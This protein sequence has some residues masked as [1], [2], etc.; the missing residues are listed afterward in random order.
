VLAANALLLVGHS[1]ETAAGQPGLLGAWGGLVQATL[2]HGGAI[3]ILARL[4]VVLLLFMVGLES[5]LAAMMQ[6]GLSSLLVA[7]VGVVAPFLLGF[8]TSYWLLPGS[9]DLMVHVFIGAT[10]AATSVGITARVLRELGRLDQPESRI[11]LGAA[12]IDDVMGLVLLAVVAGSITAQNA[13]GTLNP[14][15]VVRIAGVAL[16]FL[17]LAVVVGQRLAPRVFGLAARLPGEG[18][19]LATALVVCFL[20]AGTA[21]LI[22]LAP[23]VGAFAAGLLLDRVHYRDFRLRGDE[24]DVEE[25]IEPLAAFLVPVFFVQMGMT[26]RLE[27]FA[28]PAVIGF[29]ALLTLAAVLGKQVC[30]LAVVERGL[31]RVSVGVGMIPRGEVG[32]IFASIG[33]SLVLDGQPV[34]DEVANSAVVIMVIVTT[35]VTPPLLQYTLARSERRRDAVAGSDAERPA[36]EPTARG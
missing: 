27:S 24:H 21:N 31:D 7:T 30:G 14:L 29:A 9:H 36:E 2:A 25:L 26:V 17:G 16:L 20:L 1:P 15:D 19:L 34:V 12:V 32:L 13:G 18:V 33:R 4:G 8:A 10:L 5:N 3:D 11:I 23:I 35:L 28:N 6:V 22:G